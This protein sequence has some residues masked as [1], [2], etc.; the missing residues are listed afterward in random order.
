MEEIWHRIYINNKSTK[1]KVSNMGRI[2]SEKSNIHLQPVEDEYGYLIV[3]LRRKGKQWNKKIH[4][5]VMEAFSPVQFGDLNQVNHRDGNKKNNKFSNLEW[6]NNSEQQIHAYSIG[7]SNAK[8]GE[9]S[10]LSKYPESL[11][12][13]ICLDLEKGISSKD[14][15]NKH[16][17]SVKY[18]G[19]I[20]RKERWKH[21]VSQYNF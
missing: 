10:N 20:R 15:S 4:R 5:L 19:N 17:V 6:S 2:F 7:L 9:E 14:I 16:N 13:Q 12:H 1:Y 8:K 21:V 11:I 18:V 3:C